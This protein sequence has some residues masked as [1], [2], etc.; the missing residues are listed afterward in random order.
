MPFLFFELL[1]DILLLILFFISLVY[2]TLKKKKNLIFK[3]LFILFFVFLVTQILKIFFPT[4]RPISFYIKKKILGS[5]PSRHMAYASSLS[6]FLIKENFYLG[7]ICLF[8]SIFIG[9][10]SLFSLAHFPF[11]IFGGIVIGILIELFTDL[12]IKKLKLF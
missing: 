5:F 8:I 2:I 9:Y 4:S 11:D 1:R 7:I 10:F 3:F 6:F 12:V